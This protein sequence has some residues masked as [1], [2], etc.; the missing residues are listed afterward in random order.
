MAES[1]RTEDQRRALREALRR[2]L[3]DMAALQAA[4][5]AERREQDEL[6]SKIKAMEGKVGPGLPWACTQSKR[7]LSH[8]CM[9]TCTH[10]HA[11]TRA[12]AH[13]HTTHAHKPASPPPFPRHA[14][15]V[16]HSGVNLLDKVDELKARSVATK[17]EMEV[18]V[19][20][21]AGAQRSADFIG[22]LASRAGAGVGHA[23]PAG[24]VPLASAVPAPEGRSI[25][26][27]AMQ[28]RSAPDSPR[29]L[30]NTCTTHP[31]VLPP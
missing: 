3:A 8:A 12:R 20:F 2:R 5:E 10:V 22:G 27:G 23:A 1:G 25:K 29:A 4:A 7:A 17:Q 26:Q 13:T 11:W 30:G 9:H 31:A 18:G 6:L 14:P 24:A 19:P 21:C 28:V 15:Q 16:L